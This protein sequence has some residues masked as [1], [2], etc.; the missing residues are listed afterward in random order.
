[1]KK[2]SALVV[3]AAI[4]LLFSCSRDKLTPGEYIHWVTDKSNGLLT[5]TAIGSY[6]F[7]LQYKP[8]DYVSLQERKGENLVKDSLEKTKKELEDLQYYTFKIRSADNNEV[9]AVQTENDPEYYS[10][11]EY[12]MG[13]M[14]DDIVLVE[15]KDTLPC[16]LFH[17]ERNYG[18][19][20]DNS[21]VL[22]FEKQK[23]QKNSSD[24]TLVFNDQVLGTGPVHLTIK[25]KSIDNIPE[26]KLN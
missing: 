11:L 1:M 22:A 24:R 25:G 6:T 18:L 26:L 7:F 5:E 19:S 9:M 4:L 17:F 21:F 14:Q 2:R 13:V 3:Y 16:L 23:A 15:G 8:L 20:P 10:R 12:F